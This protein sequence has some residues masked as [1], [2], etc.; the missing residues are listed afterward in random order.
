VRQLL[1]LAPQTFNRYYEPFVGGGALFFG[2]QPGRAVLADA[3]V[4]LIECYEQVRDHSE[5]VISELGRLKNSSRDYYRIRENNPTRPAAR[6]ARF[7]YLTKLAFNGIYRVNRAT[8]QFNVPYGQRSEMMVFEQEQLR[9]ASR[10]LQSAE[11]VAGDFEAT[12]ASARKGDFVYLDPPYTLAHTNN[13]FV[14]YNTRLFSWADQRR[15]AD[16]AANLAAAGVAVIVTNAPHRS[17]LKLYPGFGRV[18]FKR[19]SQIAANV[20]FRGPVTELVLTANLAGT[21]WGER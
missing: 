4:D 17:I 19:P 14:R 15:L 20:S 16:S 7:I 11:T 5:D 6:A 21:R 1:R 9:S 18:R 2:L 13:G 10:I 12:V 8:G 3:N